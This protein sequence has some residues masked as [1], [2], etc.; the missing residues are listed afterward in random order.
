MTVV[1]FRKILRKYL[2]NEYAKIGTEL[3]KKRVW[4]HSQHSSLV[5]NIFTD[6]PLVRY[7]ATIY[8]ISLTHLAIIGHTD[9]EKSEPKS[10]Y[11]ESPD[12]LDELGKRITWYMERV[13]YYD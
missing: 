10:I 7:V 1:Q 5:I 4:S 6:A 9:S 3:E 12:S 13:S 2:H 8:V 11:L